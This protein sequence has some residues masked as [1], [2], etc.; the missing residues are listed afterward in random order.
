[1]FQMVSNFRR[2]NNHKKHKQKTNYQAQPPIKSP[3]L[4]L[5]KN[6][7]FV[8]TPSITIKSGGETQPR[9]HRDFVL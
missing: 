4:R 7:H 1:M 2:F 5:L 3:A 6:M 8:L 9:I